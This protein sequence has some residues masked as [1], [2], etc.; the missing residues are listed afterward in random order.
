M[1]GFVCSGSFYTKNRFLM[2]FLFF[3]SFF[4]QFSCFNKIV[5]NAKS[6]I[7]RLDYF[8]TP[9]RKKYPNLKKKIVTFFSRRSSDYS[10]L[11]AL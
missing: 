8:V 1:C 6:Q 9:L 4:L 11:I 3:C 2:P 5:E 7:F 10:V